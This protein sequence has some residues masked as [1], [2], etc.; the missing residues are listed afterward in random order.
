MKILTIVEKREADF[1]DLY[2][3][4]WDGAINTLQTIEEEGLQDELMDLLVDCLGDEVDTEELNDFL[5][6][7][8][9]YIFTTLGVGEE[10]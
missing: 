4:C 10:S 1:N 5:H 9:D 6:F 3:I 8:D 7:E 2:D